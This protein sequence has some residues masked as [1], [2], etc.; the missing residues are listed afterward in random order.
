MTTGGDLKGIIMGLGL[1]LTAVYRRA[2]VPDD[3]AFPYVS[4]LDPVSRIP[5]LV[6]DARTLAE[7][8]EVQVD[9]WQDKAAEDDA[10]LD[11]L[12]VGIDGTKAASG[13]R[14][15]VRD[16]SLIPGPEEDADIIHHAITVA[17]A[18]VR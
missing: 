8:H 7:S 10:L 9:L 2:W 15:R 18:Q 6:G 1:P 13:W 11:L 4:F 12:V 14:F 16:A 5:L 17:L 3:A